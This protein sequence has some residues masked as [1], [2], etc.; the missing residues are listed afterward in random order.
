MVIGP[1]VFLNPR[2]RRSGPS[3][4]RDGSYS[5][6]ARELE[7]GHMGVRHEMRA[8]WPSSLYHEALSSPIHD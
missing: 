4:V 1:R 2:T 8:V 7:H 6:H 3:D 5:T